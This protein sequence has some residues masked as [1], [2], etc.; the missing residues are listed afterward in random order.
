[1]RQIIYSI[2]TFGI[3]LLAFVACEKEI[4]SV[5]HVY[6]P[7]ELAYLD[8]LEQE[9]YKINANDSLIL[10]ITLPRDTTNYLGIDVS[11]DSTFI[12]EK[13][14][15]SSLEEFS[16]AL[17]AVSAGV[18]SGQEV[19]F[20][21]I[22]GSTGYDYTGNL[23]A[24]G[25]GYWFDANGDVVSWGETNMIFTEFNPSTASF[26]VGQH[27]GRLS[28]GNQ[29]RIIILLVKDDYRLALVFKITVGDIYV[30]EMPEAEV[31]SSYD[32]T[33][34]VIPDNSY[35]ATD[36]NFDFEQASSDMGI[37][38]DELRANLTFLGIN[39]DETNTS[40]YTA[41]AGY[42]YAKNGFVTN[43]GAEGCVLFVNYEEGVFH[44]G[45]FPDAAVEGESYTVQVGL[46]YKDTKMVQ[47]NIT[48]TVIGYVD[49]ETPPTG[50]PQSLEVAYNVMQAYAND[51]SANTRIN[52]KDTLRQAFKMTTYQI[53][54]A[55]DSGDLVFS[56]LNTDGSVYTNDEGM[57]ASTANHPGHWYG[58][59]G[60][61]TVW[62]D[63][64]NAP[65]VYSELLHGNELLEFSIG[66]HPEN[67]KPGDQFSYK[68]V[69]ELNGGKVTFTFNITIE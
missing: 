31:V 45:Q 16:A 36:L 66:H 29:H 42:W 61:V 58:R 6:T 4:P 62:A 50:D 52:V 9:K 1:M 43:W 57:P 22:S 19:D 53:H 33:L 3:F 32:L 25:L 68:Q 65:V 44:I 8:S 47:Y 51:W 59:D 7:E 18:Q 55:I 69:A 40:T 10:N 64:L 30:E 67:A 38:A 21:V 46:L 39:P 20:Q 48:V 26:V 49:P 24:N 2:L 41:D 27:P 11:I 54:Q 35:A 23:T 12:L 60:N 37:S 5:K 34:E 17:G 28:T 63:S 56:G 13:L 14:G 15:Y